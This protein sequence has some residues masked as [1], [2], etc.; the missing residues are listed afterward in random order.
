MYESRILL[1]RLYRKLLCVQVINHAAFRIIA[2]LSRKVIEKSSE[3]EKNKKKKN[4][5]KHV[6]K[7]KLF[8]T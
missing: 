5:T 1:Y 2:I 4:K 3:T 8:V 6:V 7:K